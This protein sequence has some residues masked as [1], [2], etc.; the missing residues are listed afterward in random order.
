MAAIQVNIKKAF[1]II[2]VFCLFT[3]L[4]AGEDQAGEAC[5]FSPL[6][7][8]ETALEPYISSRT[9]SFHYG[10]HYKAYV[11]KANALIK[12]SPY[13]SMSLTDIIV[14]CYNTPTNELARNIFNNAAQAW[15]HD[16]FWKCMKAGGGGQPS[17][18]LADMINSSFGSFEKFKEKFIEGGL[19][20]F[21]SGWVWLAFDGK[22][23]VIIK[24][25]NAA[26]PLIMNMKPV[27][28][29]DVWEHAYYLDYQNRRGE[30]IK[31]FLDHLVNWEFAEKQIPQ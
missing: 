31:N 17:G 4:S 21:G 16:F 1:P 5:V 26:N 24:T 19:T 18:R 12:N 28:V 2:A 7:Y 27:L 8:S 20:Q 29:C 25:L 15:N 13:K 11:E 22:K 14:K 9:L 30:F 6:P 10:K 3:L 23:L